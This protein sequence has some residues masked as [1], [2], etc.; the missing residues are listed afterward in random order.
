VEGFLKKHKRQPAF[1]DIWKEIPP[2]R[3]FRVSKKAYGKITQWQ[4]M[5]MRNVG[6]CIAAVLASALQNPDSSPYHD[7]KSALKCVSRLADFSIKTL[8]RSHTPD[9]LSYMESY[10]LTFHGTKD[11]FLR[12]RTSKATCT[13]ADRQDP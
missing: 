2:Y 10:L 3:G 6:R 12:F 1:D 4:G 13:R 8:Y 11:I 9:T 5:A 7:S